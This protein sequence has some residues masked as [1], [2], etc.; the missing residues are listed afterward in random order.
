[1][2][3]TLYE[4]LKECWAWL[5]PEGGR[6]FDACFNMDWE[7]VPAG[8]RRE[9][10]GRVGYLISG[11]AQLRTQRGMVRAGADTFFGVSQPG[12]PES[13]RVEETELWAVTECAVLWLDADVLRNVCYAACWFHARLIR[14]VDA[15]FAKG[16]EA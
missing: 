16:Q 14:E 8:A 2:D 9:S 7:T 12:R 6:Y 10:R 13:R 11:R 4:R 1:M 5:P 3:E 15:W